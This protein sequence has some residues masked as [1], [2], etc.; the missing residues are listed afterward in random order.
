MRALVAIVAGVTI[1]LSCAGSSGGAQT[2]P[3]TGYRAGAGSSPVSGAAG[4]GTVV[5]AEG[6]ERCDAPLGLVAIADPRDDMIRAL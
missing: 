1:F 5:G 3:G 4:G 6:L 2:I